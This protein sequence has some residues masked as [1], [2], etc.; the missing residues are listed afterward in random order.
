MKE[1]EISTEEKILEAAEKIFL[2]DGYSGSRMQ[3]IADLAGIN[4]ALLHYYFRSKDKLFEYIF[5]KKASIMFPSMEELFD[6]NMDFI[7]ILDLFIEKYIDLLIKN[8]FLPLFVITT[9][10]KPNSQD[11]IKKLPIGLQ[12]KL[13]EAFMKDV[14]EGKIKPLN[15]LHFIISVISMCAFPFMAKPVIMQIANASEEDFKTIM[16]SRV[17]EIQGYV[18]VLLKP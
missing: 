1:L 16:Q 6:K 17:T 12:K 14:S 4:K 5:D 10:N 3:D 9:V 8:P 18:Q 2:Q 13:V 7:E 15:P 11:F